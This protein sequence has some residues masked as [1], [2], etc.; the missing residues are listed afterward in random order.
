MTWHGSFIGTSPVG[1]GDAGRANARATAAVVAALLAFLGVIG[2]R[3]GP[4][5]RAVAQLPPVVWHKPWGGIERYEPAPDYRAARSV[6]PYSVVPGG[7]LSEAELEAAM[8]KDPV[9]ARHYR[10]ILAARLLADAASMLAVNVYAS[11]RSANSVHWTSPPDPSAERRTDSQ[12]RSQPDSSAMR[13][14]ADIHAAAQGRN[15]RRRRTAGSRTSGIGL[16]A[17]NATVLRPSG[18]AGTA[19]FAEPPPAEWHISGHR[20]CHRHLVLRCREDLPGNGHQPR[21]PGP[22]GSIGTATCYRSAAGIRDAD[23][24]LCYGLGPVTPIARRYGLAAARRR[25]R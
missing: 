10:D 3:V 2:L 9:V 11:Y 4:L 21:P 12:R 17:R 23:R 15:Q 20:P 18:V 19:A 13:Q 16:R 8:A 5:R 7:V 25:P 14:S 6:Y 24:Q 1:G 22:S